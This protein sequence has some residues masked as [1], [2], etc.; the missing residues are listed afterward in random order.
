[1]LSGRVT[2]GTIRCAACCAAALLCPVPSLAQIAHQPAGQGAMAPAP[3]STP[4]LP[5]DTRLPP[6]NPALSDALPPPRTS[7]F[8]LDSLPPQVGAWAR[9]RGQGLARGGPIPRAE[10]MPGH[11]RQAAGG[12]LGGMSSADIEAI[13]FLVLMEAAKSARE[14]LKS[15]MDKVKEI[16]EAKARLGKSR[17]ALRAAASTPGKTAPCAVADCGAARRNLVQAQ[18]LLGGQSVYAIPPS[19]NKAGVLKA[20]EQMKKTLDALSKMG[21]MDSLNLQKAMEKKSAIESVLSN[22]LKIYQQTA[23]GIIQNLK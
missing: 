18:A 1:M 16:N 10:D 11:V 21:E 5:A 2:S 23:D 20:A 7:T 13:A 3:Q 15:I 8:R 14:D 6:P 4:V 22:M 19:P 12:L 9:L 17:E